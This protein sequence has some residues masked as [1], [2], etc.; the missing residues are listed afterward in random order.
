ME[1]DLFERLTELWKHYNLFK[2]LQCSTCIYCN[3]C[4]TKYFLV[5]EI[6]DACLAY[7]MDDYYKTMVV[8]LEGRQNEKNH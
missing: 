5:P 4:K 1:L 3:E 2:P 8:S 6:R 7:V